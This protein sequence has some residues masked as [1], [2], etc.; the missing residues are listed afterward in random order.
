MSNLKKYVIHFILGDDCI[1]AEG[2]ATIE[3]PCPNMAREIFRDNVMFDFVSMEI[4]SCTKT[5]E[6]AN[7]ASLKEAAKLAEKEVVSKETN[8]QYRVF[9]SKT[10]TTYIHIYYIKQPKS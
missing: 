7:L 8:H 9:H 10:N 5:V 2:K 1:Q 3:A 4:I 6:Y